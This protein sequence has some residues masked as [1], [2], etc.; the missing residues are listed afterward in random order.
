MGLDDDMEEE[1]IQDEISELTQE[2][3]TITNRF[4]Q[5][6]KFDAP[7]TWVVFG[8]RKEERNEE[9]DVRMR[10]HEQVIKLKQGWLRPDG[11]QQVV[12]DGDN[13]DVV[14]KDDIFVT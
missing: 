12:N 9:S 1:E 2:Q 10:I 6:K 5:I 11:W 8:G 13:N 4:M 3:Q 7:E 14:S